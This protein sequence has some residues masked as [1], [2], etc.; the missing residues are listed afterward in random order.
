MP[1]AYMGL[2]E[3]V[4]PAYLSVLPDGSTATLRGCPGGDPVEIRPAA[5]NQ[6]LPAV[7]SDGLWVKI[8]DGQDQPVSPAAVGDRAP[9]SPD[10]DAPVATPADPPAP[11][12]ARTRKATQS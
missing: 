10:P 3:R 1:Y 7:P 8:A 5:G 4:Y 11:K 6:Q 12:P 2:T 9:A